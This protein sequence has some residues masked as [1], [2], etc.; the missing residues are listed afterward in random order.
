M[1]CARYM[2][3]KAESM[4]QHPGQS[5]NSLDASFEMMAIPGSTKTFWPSSCLNIPRTL[6]RQ[7]NWRDARPKMSEAAESTKTDNV[8]NVFA[9]GEGNEREAWY[10]S[11]CQDHRSRTSCY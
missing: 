10:H 2:E 1:S 4:M 3:K 7:P 11:Q 9:P 5:M 6:G 8:S